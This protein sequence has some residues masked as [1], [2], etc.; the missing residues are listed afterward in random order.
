MADV[1]QCTRYAEAGL[2]KNTRENA[3]KISKIPNSLRNIIFREKNV[4]QI[5][6]ML[7]SFS[8][9]IK[10]TVSAKFG[11]SCQ[12]LFASSDDNKDG[13]DLYATMPNGNTIT[14][15]VKFGSY[16]DKAAGMGAF[17]QI[18][19]TDVFSDAL[20]N[21]VRK[22]WQSLVMGEFPSLSEQLTRTTNALNNA[23]DIFNKIMS[24]NN[25]ILT[26]QSRE[27]MEDYLLNNSGSYESHSNNY[28]RFEVNKSGSEIKDV[29]LVKKGCGKWHVKEVHKLDPNDEKSRVNVFVYNE[30][31]NLQIKFTLNNK[32]D[33][34]LK[35]GI[36]IRSKFML[37][38]PSWNVW[39]NP[40]R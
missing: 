37:N 15:E 5:E 28:I 40:L 22:K 6:R 29:M 23:V 21:E 30:D 9:T 2:C 31:T 39:I 1:D 17:A 24:S 3:L 16:T 11:F 7:F 33:L 36:K 19:G 8:N 18:F 13:A 14:I 34:K 10:S 32:N 25:Y 35:N 38:S 20:S 26:E 27:Y 12:T 4:D